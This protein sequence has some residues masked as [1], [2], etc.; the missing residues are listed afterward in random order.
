MAGLKFKVTR[1]EAVLVPPCLPTPKDHLYLSNLD[2]QAGARFH[3]P[4]AHFY[5]HSFLK[6][7]QDP[8]KVI[9]EAL[10]KV[11]VHYYPLAGRLREAAAGKLKVECTGEGVLFV[12]ADA[13]VT[14]AEFGDLHPPFP[15]WN[16]LLHD[17]L[18]PQTVINSPLLLF[19]VTRLKCKGFV[20]A[21]LLNHIMADGIGVAQFLTALGEIAMGASGLSIPPIW[22]RETLKPRSQPS[23]RLPLYEY[24]Q[25]P[26]KIMSVDELSH[27]SYFFGPK[28][29]ESLKREAGIKTSTFE[30]LSGF[31]WRLRTRVLN[32]A[33]EQEV[34]FMFPTD[35]RTIVNPSLPR[36]YYGNAFI[37]ACVKTTAGMLVSSPLSYAV[38]LIIRARTSINN[39]YVRS[40]I[41]MM[42][43]R[44]HPHFTAV[45][46]W[47]ISDLTKIRLRDVDFGW[48]KAVYGGT[49]MGGVGAIPGI[50]TFLVPYQ[51][52][53][54]VEGKLIH[55][56]LPSHVMQ[57]FQLEFAQT[58]EKETPPFIRSPI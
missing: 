25:V 13:D 5:P 39:E 50:I 46:S 35:I 2:D 22:K 58:M 31:M 52:S 11:L 17:I 14:L 10:A 6:E 20:F 29:I 16:E 26:G 55:V 48:G 27:A 36:G 54:G 8:A 15:C 3:I 49:A 53:H 21:L 44:G 47:L 56:C 1:Q 45:A 38:E 24:E 18:T 9:R 28:E 12:E 51:N 57:K 41:D 32:M 42:E 4:L 30:A 37:L 7:D 23:I 40:T 43:V 33:A 34:R 19:Q